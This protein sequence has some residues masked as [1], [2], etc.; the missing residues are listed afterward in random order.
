MPTRADG[1]IVLRHRGFPPILLIA[2]G[3]LGLT[4]GCLLLTHTRLDP[5]GS[6][7]NADLAATP[8]TPARPT[9]TATPTAKT[10][11]K[12]P[13]TPAPTGKTKAKPKR[14]PTPTPTPRRRTATAPTSVAIVPNDLV[15]AHTGGAGVYLRRTPVMTDRLVAVPEGT[16]L[17][18]IGP[19]AAGD[20]HQW[21]H[22]RA[23]DG[24]E[25]WVPAEYTEPLTGGSP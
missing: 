18:Q 3:L 25:G 1:T 6:G 24:T 9:P 12:R 14:T 4:L 15:V 23:P 11:S 21:K 17:E 20:G 19:E 13:T 2:G 7:A 16:R 8:A 22:V 5:T 10:T